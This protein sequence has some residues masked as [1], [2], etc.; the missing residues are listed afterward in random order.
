MDL[1]GAQFILSSRE[2][3]RDDYL[4]PAPD[5]TESEAGPE[6]T[7]AALDALVRMKLT[8]FRLKD[9]V[10]LLDLLDVGLIDESWC[11]RFPPELGA[12][13]RELI[14]SMEREL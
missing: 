9:R 1:S 2:K 3:V 11:D 8:S 13:L 12:R 6:F 10:H 5:V 4:L 7:V 14:E